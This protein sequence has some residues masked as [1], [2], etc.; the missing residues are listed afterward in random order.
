L[1]D[2]RRIGTIQQVEKFQYG[3]RPYPFPE[4]KLPGEAHIQAGITWR[5]KAI[6]SG[7]EIQPVQKAISIHIDVFLW[8]CAE[9]EAAL[10]AKYTTDVEPHRKPDDPMQ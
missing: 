1:L 10:S 9:V 5:L 7:Q 4:R 6:A 3:P 8:A 2:S